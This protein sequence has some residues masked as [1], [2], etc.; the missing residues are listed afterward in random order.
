MKIENRNN[1]QE[2]CVWRVVK[3][4]LDYKLK[5]EIFIFFFDVQGIIFFKE[6]VKEVFEKVRNVNNGNLLLRNKKVIWKVLEGY[7]EKEVL[8]KIIDDQ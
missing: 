7:A 8:K 5:S 3:K 4:L 1:R 6:K 2:R